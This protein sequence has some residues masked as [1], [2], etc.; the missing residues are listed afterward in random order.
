MKFIGFWVNG[1][2]G[3]DANVHAWTGGA[4]QPIRY[5]FDED[6][7][8]DRPPVDVGAEVREQLRQ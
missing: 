8:V 2:Q 3:G 4:K 7:N 5:V 1:Y 6:G